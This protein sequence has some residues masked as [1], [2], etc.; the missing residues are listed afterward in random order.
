MDPVAALRAF[1]DALAAG[2]FE[3][4]RER[5]DALA[6][7]LSK[8]G[9]SPFAN[10]DWRCTLNRKQMVAYFREMRRVGEAV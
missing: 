5:A 7:W 6:D 10:H 3:T 9:F 2:D 4:I 8:R 1:D